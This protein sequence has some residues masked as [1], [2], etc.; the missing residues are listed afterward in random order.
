VVHFPEFYIFFLSFYEW[1]GARGRRMSA[2]HVMLCG[3]WYACYAWSGMAGDTV[4]VL[5]ASESHGALVFDTHRLIAS[6]RLYQQHMHRDDEHA[7]QKWH[8]MHGIICF[9]VAVFRYVL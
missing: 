2:W 1:A 4:R 6:T 9:S 3:C 8:L 5:A 7:D